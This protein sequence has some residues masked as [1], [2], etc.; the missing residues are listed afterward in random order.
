MHPV[1]SRVRT[2]APACRLNHTRLKARPHLAAAEPE[3]GHAVSTFLW[4]LVGA[5]YLVLLVSLGLA[6][7]RNGRFG[8]F[9][10]GIFLPLLW[11]V[12]AVMGPTPQVRALGPP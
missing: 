4:I 3:G 11:I 2:L 5:V 9:V 8:L 12:G 7:L 10:V 6:T 1:K